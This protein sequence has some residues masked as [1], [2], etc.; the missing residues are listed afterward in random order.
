MDDPDAKPVN[1]GETYV[2]WN[3]FNIPKAYTALP[4]GLSPSTLPDGMLEV[5][6]DSNAN[7]YN[8][9]CPPVRHQYFFQLY[10][11]SSATLAPDIDVPLTRVEFEQKYSNDIVESVSF[12]AFFSP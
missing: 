10:G 12:N 8:G 2:H 9:P 7:R 1:N 4:E 3:L 5:K 11:I 6:N